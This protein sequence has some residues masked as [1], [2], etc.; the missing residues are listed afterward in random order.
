M[1]LPPSLRKTPRPLLRR[2]GQHHL[3]RRGGPACG[4]GS[5]LPGRAVVRERAAGALPRGAGGGGAERE[6]ERPEW[7]GGG[8]E[9]WIQKRHAWLELVVGVGVFLSSW[10]FSIGKGEVCGGRIQP[11]TIGR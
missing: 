9:V 2:R 3:H 7:L 10:C 5:A 8:G 1:T 11:R 4:R 6:R